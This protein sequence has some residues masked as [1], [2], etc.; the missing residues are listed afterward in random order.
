METE[1][2]LLSDMVQTSAMAGFGSGLQGLLPF[3]AII[4]IMYF[5]MIRPQQKKEKQRQAMV[6]SLKRGDRVVTTGGLIGTIHKVVNDGELMVE[7]A[8]GTHVRLLSGAVTQ[9][10]DKTVTAHPKKGSSQA[11]ASAKKKEEASKAPSEVSSEE[12][13]SVKAVSSTKETQKKPVRKARTV[14]KTTK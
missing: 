4:A 11:I 8:E 3:I 7:V 5:L 6:A 1:I 13:T 10:I 14:R 2:G 12:E 9:V